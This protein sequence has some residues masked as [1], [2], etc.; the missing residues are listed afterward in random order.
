MNYT[1]KNHIDY[2][3]G[4][5]IINYNGGKVKLKKLYFVFAILLVSITLTGC[6]KNNNNDDN[7]DINTPTQYTISVTSNNLEYGQ[8]SGGA[9]VNENE[10]VVISATANENYHFLKWNDDNT[11]N[12]RTLTANSNQ[13]YTAI[14]NLGTLLRLNN[15]KNIAVVNGNVTMGET[16]TYFIISPKNPVR[17]GVWYDQN[18]NLISTNN[19]VTIHVSSISTDM[20]YTAYDT[21]IG[22]FAFTAFYEDDYN[23][24][25]D[26]YNSYS[27]YSIL[28]GT[29][30]N[31]PN[32]YDYCE[33][34]IDGDTNVTEESIDTAD[35]VYDRIYT[36][37][38][39]LEYSYNSLAIYKVFTILGTNTVQCALKQQHTSIRSGINIKISIEDFE[40]NY[41]KELNIS[42]SQR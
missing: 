21:L 39:N 34:K 35:E 9:T 3:Y 12:P 37:S 10:T 6:V 31:N 41:L 15:G 29:I 38:A 19:A 30:A 27:S 36:Y 13:S 22:L 17:F 26:Y 20:T 40:N 14:F 24:T 11:Q 18:Q 42:F 4:G 25:L 33:I 5:G 32:D 28:F 23:N 2:F 16:N 8:V 7:G 1:L